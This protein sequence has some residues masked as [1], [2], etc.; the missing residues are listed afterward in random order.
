M[1]AVARLAPVQGGGPGST[2]G[3][4]AGQRSSSL[5]LEA[6]LPSGPPCWALQ[7]HLWEGLSRC[8]GGGQKDERGD[9]PVGSD[10]ENG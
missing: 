2:E 10:Q 7:P 1:T 4:G 9:T 8:R 5:P 3:L 6:G